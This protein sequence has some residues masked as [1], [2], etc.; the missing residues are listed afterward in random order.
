MSN[1]NMF[2]QETVRQYMKQEGSP[3]QKREI[4]R[5]LALLFLI[6]SVMAMVFAG[7]Q[8]FVGTISE[9]EIAVI[10]R[11]DGR[12][13]IKDQ[14]GYFLKFREV[15]IWKKSQTL[16]FT[17]NIRANDGCSIKVITRS[18]YRLPVDRNKLQGIFFEFSN[19][20]DLHR[21]LGI[22]HQVTFRKQAIRYSSLELFHDR[23]LLVNDNVW[24]FGEINIASFE[25]KEAK[26]DEGFMERLSALREAKLKLEV[27]KAK[28][29]VLRRQQHELMEKTP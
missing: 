2:D 21:F 20:E 10:K 8:T 9:N 5:E 26:F 1:D 4:P 25:L 17:H 29:E 7:T 24:K 27:A 18:R 23:N 6:L 12:V 14:P 15:Q 28:A 22:H 16:D 19:Q 13:D 3:K 11:F